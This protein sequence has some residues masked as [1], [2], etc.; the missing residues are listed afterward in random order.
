MAQQ[1][2]PVAN[3]RP[4]AY[5]VA[6]ALAVALVWGLTRLAT[7]PLVPPEARYASAWLDGQAGQALNKALGQ[8]PGQAWV[9]RW[10]A[11]LRYRLL[12]SLG[13]QVS[14]GCPGW[15]FYRDGLQPQPGHADVFS[16]RLALMHHWASVLQSQGIGLLV[17][18]VPDKSRIQ[19]AQLCG[20]APAP[21]TQPRLDAW[22]QALLDANV[23]GVDLR[24]GLT[25]LGQA[26]YRT[27]V[28]L[29]PQGAQAAANDVAQ[30]AVPLLGGA[31]TQRYERE[32]GPQSE[33]RMGDLIV[34]AGLE[35]AQPPWRP[36]LEQV[37]P[38]R[39]EPVRSTGLLDEAALP[40][41]V[42]AGDSN[43]LRS[44]FADRLGEGLGREVWNMSR[45]GGYFSG[46][47]L[48]TL[49]RLRSAERHAVKLVVWQ[50]S[51]LSLS[52][53]LADEER[54]ALAA[55]R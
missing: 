55:L 13:P 41:V 28:H 32:Q 30:V 3:H 44:A 12:G 19:A 49:A 14:E 42:L 43:G 34:L 24:P 52:L 46:A 47:M 10:L 8:W 39:I 15:L 51:E 40:E 50:F 5:V 17:V 35:H 29:A 21:E 37:V 45:D 2:A 53:P 16:Q 9:E 26:Y 18:A 48:A 31:G 1:P 7:V 20:L 22:G 6:A 25:S 23:L 54:R 4:I 38:E 11:S 36:A 27:D 33:P